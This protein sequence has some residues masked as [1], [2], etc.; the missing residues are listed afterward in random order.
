MLSIKITPL[1]L[2]VH[3]F[4]LHPTAED[5]G[6]DPERFSEAEVRLRLERSTDRILVRFDASALARLE[7]DRTLALFDQRLEGSYTVLFAPPEHLR[8]AESAHDDVRPL[9]PADQEID[10]T[11]PVRDTL[12]LAVPARCI[13]PGAEAAE[14]P[15]R[16][17]SE[18]EGQERLD[19]RWEKLRTLREPGPDPGP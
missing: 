19:P 10:L 9:L 16:F 2:G 12:L 5:L 11:E 18:A 15:L 8:A 4:E 17:G 1:G 3:T 7:C 6:L 14:L 13:A